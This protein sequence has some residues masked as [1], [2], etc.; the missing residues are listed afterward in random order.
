M[1]QLFASLFFVT[2]F[3]PFSS[4]LLL[5]VYRFYDP[6]KSFLCFFVV[7]EVP[8][9]QE[10]G[11]QQH[12]GEDEVWCRALSE[13]WNKLDEEVRQADKNIVKLFINLKAVKSYQGF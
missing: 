7:D 2:V 6:L 9:S 3:A 13:K 12:S 8:V 10:E 1:L 5:S 4:T 11:A